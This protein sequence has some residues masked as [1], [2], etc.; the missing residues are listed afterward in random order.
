MVLQGGGFCFLIILIDDAAVPDQLCNA[1]TQGRPLLFDFCDK[2]ARSPVIKHGFEPRVFGADRPYGGD[3]GIPGEVIVPHRTP[4]KPADS[5]CVAL[6][7]N[8]GAACPIPVDVAAEFVDQPVFGS[9][10]DIDQIPVARTFFEQ[11]VFDR[12]DIVLNILLLRRIYIGVAKFRIRKIF[13][14]YGCAGSFQRG[15]AE[16]PVG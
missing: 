2:A 15:V 3:V 12:L 14:R 9:G 4:V 1:G 11:G 5:T 16:V 8:V 6:F 10:F 7:V 13:F